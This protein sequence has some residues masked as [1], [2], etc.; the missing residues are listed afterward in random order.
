[1]TE[2]ETVTIFVSFYFLFFSSVAAF[3]SAMPTFQENFPK[4]IASFAS[5]IPARQ[6]NCSIVRLNKN[7]RGWTVDDQF[8]WTNKSSS[9]N[10]LHK[11]TNR[12]TNSNVKICSSRFHRQQTICPSRRFVR[13]LVSK[14]PITK[15]ELVYQ[16]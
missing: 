9:K 13:L 10:H 12:R 15:A 3:Y 8:V 14:W 6:A 7:F 2:F 11:R 16:S 1:M 4:F 5:S